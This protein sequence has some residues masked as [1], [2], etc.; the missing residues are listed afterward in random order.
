MT[1]NII[2]NG[3]GAE[4]AGEQ[5]GVELARRHRLGCGPTRSTLMGPLQK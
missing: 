4:L 3:D 1:I 5:V 2:Y